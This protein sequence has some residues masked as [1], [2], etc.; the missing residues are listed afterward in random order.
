MLWQII[1]AALLVSAIAF[2]ATIILLFR[3]AESLPNVKS[4]IGVAS[5]VLLAS[6]FLEILPEIFEEGG[7]EVH[8]FFT[9]MLLSIISFYLIERFVHWHHCHGASCPSETRLHVVVT[10]LLGDGIHNFVDGVLIG[11]AFLVSPAVGITT[12]IA[13]IVHEIP[14]ELSDVGILIY[15]GLSKTKIIIYNFIF[16][17]TALLGAVLAYVFV[18][19]F[20][21]ILP[22][23]IAIAS[24]NFLYLALA[25]LIPVLHHEQK[26]ANIVRHTLWLLTGIAAF[27]IIT[28]L[29]GHPS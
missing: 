2:V 20:D 17:L 5:G 13:I 9:V 28:T 8:T 15:A 14:Q 27:W 19:Q 16:A 4:L 1:I 6:V 21:R 10:N 11:A 12:T 29:L 24:G 18:G 3:R 25:D 22:I 23:L 7:F 26:R